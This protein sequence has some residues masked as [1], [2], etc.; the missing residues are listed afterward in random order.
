M[1]ESCGALAGSVCARLCTYR[2]RSSS[3]D[4]DARRMWW[5]EVGSSRLIG[6][7]DIVIR[8]IL[9]VERTLDGRSL[10]EALK[11]DREPRCVDHL[12][13]HDRRSQDCEV[14]LSSVFK[15]FRAFQQTCFDKIVVMD[16]ETAV[17]LRCIAV[18]A[19]LA[20]Y[21]GDASCRG[22]GLAFTR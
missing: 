3:F 5:R 4:L 2:S 18:F 6:A 10:V 13:V 1:V 16:L 17:L 22:V 21:E 14:R 12:D 7:G 20:S 19:E 8:S 11:H 15:K 9:L